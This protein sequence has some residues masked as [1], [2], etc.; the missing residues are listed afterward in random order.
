MSGITVNL[1]GDSN[2]QAIA[3]ALKDLPDK[4][5]KSDVRAI[6]VECMKIIQRAAIDAAP[7]DTGRLREMII[8]KSGFSKKLGKV[9]VT[10]GLRKIPGKERLKIQAN[11]VAGKLSQTAIEY[12]AYY[13]VFTEFGTEHQKAQPFMRPAFDENYRAVF[14]LYGEKLRMRLE[15]RLVALKSG[16][17]S[18]R[19]A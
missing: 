8:I 9:F 15:R 17:P 5:V 6:Q 16:S 12:D 4:F 11:K 13:G 1:K 18:R 19:I 3:K 14:V 7:V 2:F 10:V